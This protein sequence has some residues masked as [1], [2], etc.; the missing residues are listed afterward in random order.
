M[1]RITPS[2]CQGVVE[3]PGKK[4][5]QEMFTLSAVSTSTSST[6]MPLGSDA[7]AI[8]TGTIL[9]GCI[10]ETIAAV[11]AAHRLVGTTDAAVARALTRVV[12]EEGRHAAMAWRALAWLLDVG[13][14]P[15]WIAVQQAFDAPRTAASGPE[16]VG[17]GVHHGLLG[18]AA[19]RVAHQQAWNDVIRPAWHARRAE[20]MES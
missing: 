17:A 14:E 20:R 18:R 4:K 8:M 11:E 16:H 1:A 2:S 9:E 10:G 6:A 12:D 7:F 15:A 13:G 3:L 19:L 5:C